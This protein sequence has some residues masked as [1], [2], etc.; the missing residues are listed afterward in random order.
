MAS[1]EQWKGLKQACLAQLRGQKLL[2]TDYGALASR[3]EGEPGGGGGQEG[4]DE[5]GMWQLEQRTV[6]TRPKPGCREGCSQNL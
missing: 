4:R 3:L 5:C 1:R 6:T 2:S